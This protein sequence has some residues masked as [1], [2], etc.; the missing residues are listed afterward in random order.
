VLYGADAVKEQQLYKLAK[1]AKAAAEVAKAA[2][3][4]AKKAAKAAEQEAAKKSA[5]AAKKAA[6]AAEQ[7][8]AKK[9]KAAKKAAKDAVKK[10]QK[11]KHKVWSAS[12]R[13]DQPA[14]R[15]GTKYKKT[16]EPVA[17]FRVITGGAL[18]AIGKFDSMAEASAAAGIL[19]GAAKN[20]QGTA[21]GHGLPTTTTWYA[22]SSRGPPQRSLPRSLPLP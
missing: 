8:A 21:R 5:K 6:K 12:R 20:G 3:K 1:V 7:E 16:L 2:A 22:P 15:T 19:G 9:A 17:V 14:R 18:Q 11:R 13:L 10:G 4:A